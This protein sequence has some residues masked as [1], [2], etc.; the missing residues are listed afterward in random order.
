MS[1]ARLAIR[2]VTRSRP[3]LAVFARQTLAFRNYSAAAELSKETIQSRVLNVLKGFEK[4][5]AAKARII[6]SLNGNYSY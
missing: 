4:V 6:Y 5:D 3:V 1:F 2:S